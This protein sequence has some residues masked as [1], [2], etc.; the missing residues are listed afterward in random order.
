MDKHTEEQLA[1][2]VDQECG[3]F[4]GDLYRS[5]ADPEYRYLYIKEEIKTAGE[6]AA[7]KASAAIKKKLSKRGPKEKPIIGK[8]SDSV[9]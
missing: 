5:L 9:K 4:I 3:N 6:Y 7:A 1:K 2:Q 8:L